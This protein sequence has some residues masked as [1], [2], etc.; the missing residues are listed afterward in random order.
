M[1]ACPILGGGP[2]LKE[3]HHISHSA[4]QGPSGFCVWVLLI[5]EQVAFSF[6]SILGVCCSRVGSRGLRSGN[7]KH[8]SFG[9]P[10]HEHLANYDSLH[11]HDSSW[12]MFRRTAAIITWVKGPHTSKRHVILPLITM[13]PWTCATLLLLSA[14]V[15]HP[16]RNFLVLGRERLS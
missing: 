9:L 11:Y 10:R 1:G 2:F 16:R 12:A 3:A 14:K 8:L 4:S 7:A 13:A 6:L 5:A 15:W